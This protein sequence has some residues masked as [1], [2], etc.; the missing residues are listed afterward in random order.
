MTSGQLARHLLHS[1]STPAFYNPTYP[2]SNTWSLTLDLQH[3]IS[4]GDATIDITYAVFQFNGRH[5]YRL[6]NVGNSYHS[7]TAPG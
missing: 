5:A 4:V 6:S 3:K 1:I 7:A 2:Q